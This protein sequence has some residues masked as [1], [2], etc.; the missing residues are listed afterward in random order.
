MRWRPTGISRIRSSGG[1]P[2]PAEQSFESDREVE[3]AAD[4][5]LAALECLYAGQ[6]ALAQTS[7]GFGVG[8]QRDVRLAARGAPAYAGAVGRASHLPG[9]AEVAEL[10]VVGRVEAGVGAEVAVGKRPEC[11][12]DA[13]EALSVFHP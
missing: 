9:V 5:K 2:G 7:P 11:I 12:V 8:R 1:R 13:R 10:D 6:L 3:I 4:R